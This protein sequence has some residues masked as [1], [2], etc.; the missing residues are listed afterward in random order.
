MHNVSSSPMEENK[1]KTEC[2]I[3]AP[4]LFKSLCSLQK[5]VVKK[6]NYLSLELVMPSGR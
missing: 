1:L 5:I 2:W 6:Y 3:A 4:I